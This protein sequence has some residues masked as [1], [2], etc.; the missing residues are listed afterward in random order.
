MIKVSPNE[1]N[2][3]SSLWPFATW[4]IDVIGPIEQTA[5]NGHRFIL[6]AIDH[7]TKWAED[8]SYKVVTKKVITYFVKDRIVCQFRVPE[9]IVIDNAVN[10]N[11]D[12]MKAICETF[13]IKHK[14]STTYRPQIN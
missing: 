12:L 8:A 11:S 10:I 4:G 2:A 14:N 13:K 7:F 5:S 9:S 6:V 3:T 1:L